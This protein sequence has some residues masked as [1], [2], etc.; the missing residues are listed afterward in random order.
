[1]GAKIIGDRRRSQHADEELMHIV[2]ALCAAGEAE[3]GEF[4]LG[5]LELHE[6]IDFFFKVYL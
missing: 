6:E 4:H 5:R 1:M 2:G 3:R